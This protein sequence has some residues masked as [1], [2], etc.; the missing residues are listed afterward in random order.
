MGILEHIKVREDVLDPQFDEKSAPSLG[1][2]HLGSEPEI[3]SDSTEFFRRTLITREMARVLRNIADVLTGR[4]GNKVV[5]LESLFG[6]GKTHTLI[7]IYHAI[8]NPLSLLEAKTDEPTTR[9]IVKGIVKDLQGLNARIVVID[10]TF[11]SLAPTP[12]KPLSVKGTDYVVKTIWGSLAHQ[13]G[14]YAKLSKYDSNIATPSAEDITGVFEEPV[15]ILMDEIA[16]YV[17]RV[18]NINISNINNGLYARTVLSFIEHLAKAV[19]MTKNVVL[20]VSLPVSMSG[21]EEERY[22]GTT[23]V[24]D[25]RKSLR[26]VSSMEIAPVSPSNI[27][28]VL[29]TRL[30]EHIDEDYGRHVAETLRKICTDP[31]NMEYFGEDIDKELLRVYDTYPFHPV[32]I[33]ILVELVDKHENLQKTRDAIK[34]TRKVLRHII[35]AKA[36]EE[37]I[38]PYHI[39]IEDEE[40]RSLLLAHQTYQPYNIVVEKDIVEAPKKLEE[41]EDLGRAIAKVI[42]LK[43][44]IYENIRKNLRL[45]PDARYVLLAVTEPYTFLS[46][47]LSAP[48]VIEVLN[49]LKN[50][51][52]YLVEEEN[53]YWFIKIQ[54]PIALL[55]SEVVKYSDAEA[56]KKLAEEIKRLMFISPKTLASTK[57][58][59][60]SHMRTDTPFDVR[61]SKVLETPE[62]IDYDEPKYVILASMKNIDGD[63]A[64]QVVFQLPDGRT[65]KYANTV[66]L[67][68]PSTNER[69][70]VILHLVKKLI[71]CDNLLKRLDEFYDD[72]L[73]ATAAKNKLNSYCYTD[74]NSIFQQLLIATVRHLDRVAYPSMNEERRTIVEVAEVPNAGFDDAIVDLV[75]SSLK[76]VVPPKY[77][78]KT[79]LDFTQLSSL[80]KTMGIDLANG[81]RPYTVSTIKEFFLTNP[82]LPVVT[83]DSLKSAL[84]DGL[85]DGLI[86]IKRGNRVYYKRVHDYVKGSDCN[87]YRANDFP[88]IDEA[89]ISDSDIILPWRMALTELVEGLR[90]TEGEERVSSKIRKTWYAFCID[91][92]LVPVAEAMKKYSG[93][94]ALLKESPIV[95][96]TEEIEEG[97]NLVVD[98]PEVVTNPGK[99]VEIAVRVERIGEFTGQI[100]LV[101]DVGTLSENTVTINEKEQAKEVHWFIEA[102]PEPGTHKYSIK[103]VGENGERYK[104]VSVVLRVIETG[105]RPV[106]GVPPKGT[107]VTKIVI[108][109]T[110]HN[111]KP[112]NILKMKLG[113]VVIVEEVKVTARATVQGRVPE[114]TIT[115]RNMSMDELL[116]FITTLSYSYMQSIKEMSYY[117]VLKPAHG[118]ELLVPDME[119]EKKDLENYL[120]YYI[121]FNEG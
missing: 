97:V 68:Y 47:N 63:T 14:K 79:E 16:D 115:G 10:S 54:S 59:R 100:T 11:S 36:K 55:N 20:V 45:Y 67:V 87:E 23:I 21:K 113:N 27:V 89:W 17:V 71:A 64:E 3:Y 30:F 4:G 105:E 50:N 13:L 111:L 118:T 86:G 6:G 108:E 112:L 65:R 52:L 107:K 84:I 58:I 95:K 25:I 94:L 62:P 110:K 15:V 40:F 90:K 43:T 8:K 99:R 51:L 69:L 29:K 92:V 31:V 39:N 104:E 106:R 121:S 78:D 1:G 24:E 119:K 73:I 38:M 88:D 116:R 72:E 35:E 7:T 102:P 70:G 2:V 56:I 42:F 82:A 57:Q 75:L 114:I 34:I 9:E 80:L 96:I 83:A 37:L 26:R 22:R 18:S 32:Y 101:P 93:N 81:E 12:V 91:G 103:A 66:Y 77:Y 120:I 53:R 46:R 41:R 33:D 109:S 61:D 60:K 117:V 19:E 49:W 28:K 85:I 48:D 76:Q 5:L 44:F 98:E 74:A